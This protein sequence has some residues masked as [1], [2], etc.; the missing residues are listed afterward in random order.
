MQVFFDIQHLYYIP[1]YIP[2][3]NTLESKNIGCTFVLHQQDNLNEVLESYVSVNELNCIWV[4]CANEARELYHIKKPEWIIFGNAYD[5]LDIIHQH[6]KTALMQHGIGPKA[7][8]YEV[9]KSPIMYRFVE[10]KHRL[11]RLQKLF[12]EK[13]FIDTGY[14]KLDPIVNNDK[15]IQLDLLQLKLDPKKHT[16]LYAPTFYPSS[17]ECLPK[18]FPELLSQYNIIIKPHFFSL[19][20]SSYKSQKA[21]LTNWA[22]Y[23]NVYL[24]DINEVSILPFMKLASLMISDASSTLFEFTALNKPAIWC[25]F[26][27]LRWSYRGIFKFRLKNRLDDDLKY[28][29]KVATQVRALEELLNA[30][31]HQIKTP[32]LKENERLEMSEYLI[33]RIDGMCS[34]RIARFLLQE[35]TK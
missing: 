16:L 22:K 26:Y 27:K 3:K 15:S 13:Q 11:N 5:D 8:Y 34:E 4:K 28:F 33:G 12:P 29:G 30:I 18:N 20:K 9:S 6:S 24:S 23:P 10:G 17:I 7:C 1:Q 35:G 32:G 21:R 19:V 2:V 31:D 14:A 25:D